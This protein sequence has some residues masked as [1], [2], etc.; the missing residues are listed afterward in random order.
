[1]R[2]GVEADLADI[3]ALLERC[4]LPIADVREARP[5]FVVAFDG[6]KLIGAGALQ[7]FGKVAL[8]RSVAIDTSRRGSGVGATIVRH[9]EHLAR[10]QS[11]TEVVLLTETAKTFFEKLG[12]REI[13]RAKAPVAVHESAEF[14]TLCPS[15]AVCMLKSLRH[16]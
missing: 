6:T 10:E 9:L 16:E 1:L 13:E 11:I 3:V 4:E 5:E 2:K 8:V 14:R 12:Y 7:K 15:T